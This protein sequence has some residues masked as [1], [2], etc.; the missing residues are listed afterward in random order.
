M[1]FKLVKLNDYLSGKELFRKLI[2]RIKALISDKN[3]DMA[4]FKI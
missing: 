3:S 2:F 4:V 1:V